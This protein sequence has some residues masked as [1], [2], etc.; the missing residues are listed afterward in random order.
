MITE[1]NEDS[2]SIPAES[3]A[4]S[5]PNPDMMQDVASPPP[6]QPLQPPAT[7][8]SPSSRPHARD[9]NVPEKVAFRPG[10][11]GRR[12]PP[13]TGTEYKAYGGWSSAVVT[14]PP[15]NCGSRV[16]SAESGRRRAPRSRLSHCRTLQ[17]CTLPATPQTEEK[18]TQEQRPLTGTTDV[19][20]TSSN[21]TALPLLDAGS[22]TSAPEAAAAILPWTKTT[23]RARAATAPSNSKPGQTLTPRP[24]QSETVQ[25]LSTPRPPGVSERT[26]KR[27]LSK[28]YSAYAQE[29]AASLLPEVPGGFSDTW[30]TSGEDGYR[31]AIFHAAVRCREFQ[32]SQGID[33][34]AAE[35]DGIF[36]F[37]GHIGP[38]Q[39]ENLHSAC[40]LF[41]EMCKV[42]SPIQSVLKFLHSEMLGCIFEGYSPGADVKKL[43]PFFVHTH[44]AAKVLERDSQRA[45]D[46]ENRRDVLQQKVQ[47]LQEEVHKL[48]ATAQHEKRQ[49][50]QANETYESICKQRNDLRTKIVSLEESNSIR[51]DEVREASHELSALQASSYIHRRD[52]ET[53][54]RE[55]SSLANQLKETK[56]R[57]HTLQHRVTDLQEALTL[58][59]DNEDVHRAA[60]AAAISA[61]AA[62]GFSMASLDLPDQL[63]Q[64]L[65]FL[66]SRGGA[67]RGARGR[68]QERKDAGGTDANAAEEEQTMVDGKR[69]LRAPL[70]D[71]GYQV[72]LKGRVD[73]V[74]GMQPPTSA[75]LAAAA[76][77]ASGR[78]S[79]NQGPPPVLVVSGEAFS[80][81]TISLGLPS[82]TDPLQYGASSDET[83]VKEVS[84]K[85]ESLA[86][87]HGALLEL[88]RS[89]RQ[90]LKRTL[91]LV[92]TW[93]L[94][95]LRGL[96]KTTMVFDPEETTFVPDP[97]AGLKC[98][99]GLGEGPDV[100]PF[101]RYDGL[102]TLRTM[103]VAQ[104]D[105][106]CTD[107]WLAKTD[108]FL[109]EERAGRP[110]LGLDSFL[111]KVFLPSCH[112]TRPAQMELMYNFLLI[113][114]QRTSLWEEKVFPDGDSPAP[115]DITT[116]S[117]TSKPKLMRAKSSRV[118]PS[119]SKDG[120]DKNLKEPS[121]SPAESN[122]ATPTPATHKEPPKMIQQAPGLFF[123]PAET[124]YRGLLGELHE[125]AFHDA[126]AMLACLCRLLV[127]LRSRFSIERGDSNAILEG[128]SQDEAPIMI[129][130]S[131]ISAVF[132]LFFP[133]KQ[134]E[135]VS[136]L[137]QLLL[138][139]CKADDSRSE[140]QLI[141]VTD[142][143]NIPNLSGSRMCSGAGQLLDNLLRNAT[144]I[145]QEMRRQHLV[146][147]LGFID[148]LTR[149]LRVIAR[150][151]NT[152]GLTE[153]PA[154]TGE[155]GAPPTEKAGSRG[156]HV[157]AQQVFDA[158]KTA[159]RDLTQDQC[160][161]YLL[162]GF[163]RRLPD[164][165]SP[166]A[167]LEEE[168]N[169][170]ELTHFEGQEAV[171]AAGRVQ[172]VRKMIQEHAQELIDKSV[173][174]Q[175]DEF[176]R[177]LTNSGVTKGGRYWQPDMTC[178][179]I[180]QEAGLNQVTDSTPS[181]DLLG[182]VETFVPGTGDDVDAKSQPKDSFRRKRGGEGSS[183]K[184][185][186]RKSNSPMTRKK[187]TTS[188]EALKAL[189]QCLH[190][191][192]DQYR[193]LIDVGREVQEL[194]VGYPGLNLSYWMK[195]PQ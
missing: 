10:L 71:G 52:L 75:A 20:G 142:M 158:L 155:D 107:I 163:G 12:K 24:A 168:F 30:H 105:S 162:R 137:K 182:F 37:Q 145:V 167:G 129:S 17:E 169:V 146:E 185:S 14:T 6:Q 47:Q 194:S 95:E 13:A 27:A 112:P 149:A 138:P 7:P 64:E 98:L 2:Q 120:K 99:V 33:E 69:L 79:G 141:N 23:P 51:F 159:D 192:F 96:L 70:Q 90:D 55:I 74:L 195:P 3:D 128:C 73:D 43:T 35:D 8:S 86:K 53:A 186:P 156:G 56:A 161:L 65:N 29:V 54:K 170:S 175:A 9:Y 152:A 63:A 45:Q 106:I 144:P 123:A 150:R 172:K 21:F 103:P 57:N 116:E 114:R 154:P 34:S 49:Q 190:D 4:G 153:A 133:V 18:L 28:E 122:S 119:F 38:P 88:Y 59:G 41:E 189:T 164:M 58:L 11:I 102:L 191:P 26:K 97:V 62:G 181:G 147:C 176:V 183:K 40:M 118:G 134:R 180:S 193:F 44:A 151:Q 184:S 101:L 110:R 16:C 115:K 100:P 84:M 104:V 109:E 77:P 39:L 91:Q 165:P 121:Q 5:A 117:F 72:V 125:D 139:G 135:H 136:A 166:A 89:L 66:T 143:F 1:Q 160:Y 132:R 46:A 50:K 25:R 174:A 42:S 179:E 177:R 188:A 92:P 60:T 93:N 19:F 140:A 78:H 113:L 130:V 22:P 108:L 36:A 31:S 171:D 111:N 32:H 94:D 48:R 76:A 81:L 126:S 82:P 173:T 187:D 157:S 85:V 68:R 148:R 80:A 61:G 127:S 87:E 131:V 124:L 15:T 83:L 67:A 178:A